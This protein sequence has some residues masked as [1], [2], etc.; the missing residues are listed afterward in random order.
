LRRAAELDPENPEL[1]AAVAF[2]EVMSARMS[3]A[4]KRGAS[5]ASPDKAWDILSADQ[6][7][8]VHGKMDRLTKLMEL[9]S[10][11]KAASAAMFLGLL[12]LVVVEDE[13][14]AEVSLRRAVTLN[15]SNQKA[16]EALLLTF[17][18]EERYEK[19]AE[20]GEAMVKAIDTSRSHL[21]L[22]KAYEKLNRWDKVTEEAQAAVKAAPDDIT[23]KLALACALLR[24]NDENLEHASAGLLESGNVD[25]KQAEA[26]LRVHGLFFCGLYMALEGQADQ[27]RPF[28]EQALHLQPD[29]EGAKKALA[30]IDSWK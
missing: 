22:A 20:A 4:L 15:P 23:A 27:A 9:P 8:S 21:C 17:A 7:K 28:L 11:E 19:M 2:A 3:Q 13:L 12:Q 5:D 10:K 14:G 30:I 16:Q 26:D 6:A 25:I 29:H 1:L 24:L 18:T